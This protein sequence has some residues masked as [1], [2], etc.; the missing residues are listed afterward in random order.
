MNSSVPKQHFEGTFHGKILLRLYKC[1]ALKCFIYQISVGDMV[2]NKYK[3][4]SLWQYFL[5]PLVW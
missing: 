5:Y 1:Y 4:I 3:E 2:L